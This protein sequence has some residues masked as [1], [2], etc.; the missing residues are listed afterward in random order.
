LFIFITY[1]KA[2]RHIYVDGDLLFNNC[3]RNTRMRILLWYQ[4]S[5][6][7]N[8]R[9]SR[10]NLFIFCFSLRNGYGSSDLHY[11][12]KHQ[13]PRDNYENLHHRWNEFLLMTNFQIHRYFLSVNAHVSVRACM[14]VAW[15]NEKNEDGKK[16]NA[17]SKISIC[18]L[19]I[20]A[21]KR[22]NISTDGI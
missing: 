3:Y 7:S 12:R 19:S 21:N 22:L 5:R 9:N 6:Y 17:V 16:F 14:R 4:V 20:L 18:R 11:A 10:R 15:H 2:I 1:A 8:R 13:K